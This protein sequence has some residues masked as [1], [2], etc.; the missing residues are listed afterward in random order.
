M[1]NLKTINGINISNFLDTYTE[2][3]NTSLS[4][5]N[6]TVHGNIKLNNTD[7]NSEYFD[8][9]KL[10]RLATLLSSHDFIQV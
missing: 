3:I 8:V 1:L 10:N 6:I 4:F 5:K 2:D 9:S 7:K